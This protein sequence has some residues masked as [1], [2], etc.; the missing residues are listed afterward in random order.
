MKK[1]LPWARILLQVHDSLVFQVPFHRAEQYDAMLSVL[2][3]PVPYPDPLVIPWGLAK[4]TKSWGD[5][6]KIELPLAA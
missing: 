1:Y 5:C 2:Q 3:N 6:E 4:S